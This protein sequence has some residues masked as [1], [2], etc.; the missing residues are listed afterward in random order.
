MPVI[1][2]WKDIPGFFDF[3]DIYDIAIQE[4]RDGNGFAEVGCFLGKSIAYM[5]EGINGSG[6][7]IR[8]FAVDLW[9]SE[10]YADW[11]N[12][13]DHPY[14]DPPAGL[15][16]IGKTLWDGFNYCTAEAGVRECIETVRMKSEAAA[17]TFADGSLSFVFID[18]DHRYDAVAQD[19]RSWSSKVKP[20]G[21]LAG[22]DYTDEWPGVVKAVDEAFGDRVQ[23]FGCSW[24]VRI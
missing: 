24:M 7:Q 15:N 2:S 6:K 12:K 18:A 22:H 23:R 21:I 16:L 4:A 3:Q 17:E 20:G 5:A 10:D 8:L 13:C 19:I 14:P 11:W 9:D 1:R